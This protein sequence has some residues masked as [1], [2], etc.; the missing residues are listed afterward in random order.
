MY[1]SDGMM[2]WIEKRAFARHHKHEVINKKNIQEETERAESVED[3]LVAKIAELESDI[4][5]LKEK[6]SGLK[7]EVVDGIDENT[8]SGLYIVAYDNVELPTLVFNDGYHFYV[9]QSTDQTDAEVK[10]SPGNIWS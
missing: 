1:K 6:N 2:N 10:S 3:K 4:N 8:S 5:E 7:I 9:W